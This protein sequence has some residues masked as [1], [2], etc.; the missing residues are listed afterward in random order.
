MRPDVGGLRHH[1]EVPTDHP[2]AQLLTALDS[3]D[4]GVRHVR[5]LPA[6][7]AVR[8]EWPEWVPPEVRDALGAIGIT[9][10]WPHQAEAATHAFE[11]R[12]VVIATGTASGKS[13]AYLLPLLTEAASG[14]ADGS[15]EGRTLYLAPTKA[16]AADQARAVAEFEVPGL[17]P[18]IVDGDTPFEHRQWAQ[19]FANLVLSNPDLLHHSLLPRHRM[20]RSLLKN[21]K[22]VV[23]D[24]CHVYRGVFGAHVA[25]TLR[26]LLRLAE[27]YGANPVVIAAS[28][29]A[30]DPAASLSVLTGRPAVAVTEDHSPHPGATVALW[31]PVTHVIDGEPQQASTLSETARMLAQLVRRGVRTLAFVPSRRGAEIVA[32]EARS[33]LGADPAA[34]RIAAYRAGYLREHRRDLE[35]D[36]REGRLLGVATTNALE[37]GIDVTGLDAVLLCGYPGRLASFWQQIGR[38]GRGDTEALA[39][40]LA[41]DDPLDTFLV[42]HPEAIFDRPVEA[43]VCDPSNPYVLA[44][45]LCLA[46]EELPLKESDLASIPGSLAVAEQLCEQKLLRRRPG[47]RYYWVGSERPEVT[48]RGSGPMGVD[49][50]E[51]NTGRLIGTVDAAASHRLVH[52]GALYLHQGESYVVDDLDLDEGLAL[53]HRAKP[54]W[55]TTTQEITH[56]EILGERERL[57]MGDVTLSLGEV[58]VTS[59]VISYQRRRLPSGEVIDTQSLDLPPQT[60]RTVAVWWTVDPESLGGLKDLAGSLHAAEHASIGLLPLVATCD[61]WDIGG[62][63]TAAHMDTELPTVFVYDGH[64][65][66]AGFAEQ[67]FREWT[68]WLGATRNAI[69]GCEC[70]AGCPGCIQSPKCGNGN[71]PLSKRGAI[72]LLDKVLK[73]GEGPVTATTFA[74]GAEKE[75]EDDLWPGDF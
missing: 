49:I 18:A 39:V 15:G 9:R 13:L 72:T 55:T 41:K 37:L 30:A 66:G 68:D 16:L 17:I 4:G 73:A 27:H 46:A 64:P 26:R 48:L 75:P 7:R 52:R 51:V 8:T 56:L 22:Y 28:A 67:A 47:G 11:G 53:V 5:R 42:H 74:A 6:R 43:S 50:A 3:E 58:E 29:T 34:G 54:P 62:L 20:W 35:A 10:P 2:A 1:W 24:E 71:E 12:D 57:E 40:M 25:L 33:R 38:A 69:T 36:L 44:G 45:H 23:V 65:G 19:R 32:A 60:L 61:R 21:L 63:S 14:P 59:C 31:E 70:T